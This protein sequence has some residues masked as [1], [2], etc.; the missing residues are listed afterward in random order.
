MVVTSADGGASWSTPVTVNSSRKDQVYPWAAVGPDGLLRV[1]Y[2]DRD[3]SGPAGQPCV[4]GYTL[5]T[6]TDL[7]ARRFTRQAVE[8]ALSIA[9]D[10]RWFRSPTT[11]VPNNTRFI[12][13]YTN[14][15]VGPDG[16][17][18]SHWTDMR[19]T[20]TIFGRTGKDQDAVVATTP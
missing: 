8:S 17:T 19:Q 9:S 7:T 18:Y 15:G 5:S 6:A 1:G 16:T 3:R 14:I 20:K 10:S 13:D 2:I 11:S 4:Y 12:G